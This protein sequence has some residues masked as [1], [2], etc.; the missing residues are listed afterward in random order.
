MPSN[1]LIQ[2]AVGGVRGSLTRVISV[3]AAFTGSIRSVARSAVQS[4]C[5]PAARLA[6]PSR[7]STPGRRLFS[8]TFA[9]V[10]RTVEMEVSGLGVGGGL[11]LPTPACRH[12]LPP[13]AAAACHRAQPVVVSYWH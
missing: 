3:P 13:P 12:L 10:K 8:V 5:P 11:L 4:W 6:A 7:R 9:A 2:S 1:S